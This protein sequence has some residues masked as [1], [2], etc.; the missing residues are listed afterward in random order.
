MARRKVRRRRKAWIYKCS[1]GPDHGYHWKSGF[2]KKDGNRVDKNFGGEEWIRSPLSWANLAEARAGDL[3]FCHQTDS[4]GLVGLTVAASDGYP[5]PKGKR[6]DKCT[7]LDIGPERVVFDKVVTVPE[8]REALDNVR[9]KAYTAGL[10]QHTFHPVEDHLVEPLLELCC[11]LNPE[12]H[13]AIEALWGRRVDAGTLQAAKP[14][15]IISDPVRREI[16]VETYERHAKWARQARRLYGYSCMLPRC[17][18]KL[19]QEN[20]EL[21]IE[22]HHLRWMCK[23]GSPNDPK[24]L[25]VL[26]P[27]HHRKVHY[28]KPGLRQ[29]LKQL[30][31]A[32]QRRRLR[33]RRR[34]SPQ[35]GGSASR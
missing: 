8:I 9:M 15:E 25:S 14:E 26:C 6:A 3:V 10:S 18:F 5:D 34:A 20:G 30:I 32:Q 29:R 27:N 13:T 2:L 24:N 17:T 23:G 22:V 28:G 21:F 35:R 4:N 7:T 1:Q 19:K 12:Q 11:E 33:D 31:R 16:V